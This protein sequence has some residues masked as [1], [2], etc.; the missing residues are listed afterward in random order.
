MCIETVS[1]TYPEPEQD[2]EHP[3]GWELI[4]QVRTGQKTAKRA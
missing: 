1:K 3:I 2:K 4:G